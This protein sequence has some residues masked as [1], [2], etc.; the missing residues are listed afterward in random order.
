MSHNCTGTT[1]QAVAILVRPC[2]TGHVTQ[3]QH[4]YK[5]PAALCANILHWTHE[6]TAVLLCLQDEVLIAGFGRRGHAVGDIPG[7]R[8]KVRNRVSFELM[9]AMYV[10]ERQ[11]FSF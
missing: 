11:G 5:I 7:V 9:D 2:S 4:H 10:N 6:E 1:A 8:F 3:C